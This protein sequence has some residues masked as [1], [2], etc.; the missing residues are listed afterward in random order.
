MI[1]TGCSSGFGL[2]F[3]AAF[4]RRGDR[5]VATMR[6]TARAKALRERITTERLENVEICALDV[7]DAKA[8]L[9][10]IDDVAARYGV[11]DV[12]VNNA[13]RAAMG[14]LETLT[15][16]DMRGIFNTNVVGAMAVT[17]AVLPHMRKQ[18]SGHVVFVTA[19]GAVVNT[20]WMGAYCGSKHAIDSMAAVLDLEVRPLGI[21]VSSIVPAAFRTPLAERGAASIEVP[22]PY[23]DRAELFAAGFGRR[24]AESTDLRPVVDALLDVVDASDPPLR[25][26]VAPGKEDLFGPLVQELDARH[27]QDVT[28]H[29]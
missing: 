20:P 23:R 16:E 26:L 17:Q 12:L 22:E 8:A 10:V 2:E 3:A 7:T 28:A 13:G 25:R 24:V 14:P 27:E 11:I 18:A 9:V 5:V 6:D 21:R 19:L 1:I 15:V 29:C 4:A